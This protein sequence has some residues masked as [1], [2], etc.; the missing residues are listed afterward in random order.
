[1]KN[2]EAEGETSL[3]TQSPNHLTIAF[4]PIGYV[5]ND[6]DAPTTPEIIAAAESRIVVAPLYR[7][8]GGSLSKG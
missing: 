2:R 1:M 6:F 5:E 8:S 4:T 3:T 7:N